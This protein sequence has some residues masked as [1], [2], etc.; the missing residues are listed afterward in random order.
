MKIKS[1]LITGLFSAGAFVVT[2]A[3]GVPAIGSVSFSGGFETVGMTT[4]IVSALLFIDVLNGATATLAQACTGVFTGCPVAGPF[5]SDFSL[6]IPSS[7]ILYTFAG[8]TFTYTGPFAVIRTPLSCAQS[9]CADALSFTTTGIVT[10]NGFTPTASSL[11]WSAAGTCVQSMN[12]NV[13]DA[14]FSGNS[15]GA[16]NGGS[17]ALPPNVVAIWSSSIAAI[18][19]QVVPE[20]GTVSLLGLALA[21]LGFMG[22]RRNT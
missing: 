12:G 20:P 16:T 2:P 15:V 3:Q 5:A 8:F 13:C 4:D 10:G 1:F 7:Q 22:W 19:T 21:L 17:N 9:V 6:V 14:G 18:G 11:V